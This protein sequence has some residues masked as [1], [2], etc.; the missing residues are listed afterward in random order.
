MVINPNIVEIDGNR[1]DAFEI[2]AFLPFPILPSSSG[3]F[4]YNRDFFFS[5]LNEFSQFQKNLMVSFL[6]VT[7]QFLLKH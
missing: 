7:V 3:H 2:Y 4:P 5:N 6:D 1:C